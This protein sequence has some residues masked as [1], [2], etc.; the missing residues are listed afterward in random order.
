MSSP[1]REPLQQVESQ[2]DD[3]ARTLAGVSSLDAAGVERVAERLERLASQLMDV[4]APPA[5][6]GVH[7][8]LRTVPARAEDFASL[9]DAMGRADGEG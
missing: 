8:R 1:P 3:A 7:T 4:S 6:D 9:A 5:M 2:L